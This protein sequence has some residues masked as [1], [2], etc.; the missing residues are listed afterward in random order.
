MHY[1]RT[2]SI[3]TCTII[4]GGSLE[5]RKCYHLRLPETKGKAEFGKHMTA[6]IRQLGS[7]TSH[8]LQIGQRETK[9]SLTK[10]PKQN[11]CL[12]REAETGKVQ[13]VTVCMVQWACARKKYKNEV[14]V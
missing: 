13:I 6:F 12:I 4:S 10:L 7:K 11:H 1:E 14:N 8:V 3:E 2:R 9:L 5:I